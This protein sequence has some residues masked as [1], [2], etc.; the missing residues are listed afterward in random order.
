[1]KTLYKPNF[2]RFFKKQTKQ[3]KTLIKEEIKKLEANPNLGVQKK[4]DLGEFFVYKFKHNRQEYLLAYIYNPETM[5]I[6]A[7]GLHENFYRDLK[8]GL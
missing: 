8:R 7:L 6:Y 3:F 4:G 1:M 2:L 5:T